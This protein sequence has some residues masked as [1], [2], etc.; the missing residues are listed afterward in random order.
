MDYEKLLKRAISKVPEKVKEKERLEVPKA[1][2][3]NMGKK[4]SIRNFSVISSTIRREPKHVLK[5]LSKELASP[6]I[7]DGSTVVFSA[8]LPPKLI[9]DKI[10]L[11]IKNYVVCPECKKLDTKFIKEGKVLF[12]KCEACG[13]KKSLALV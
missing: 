13:A 11:Y 8:R 5:F 7:L 9:Q 6:G 1:N 3:T 10:D 4:T 12:I 2:I